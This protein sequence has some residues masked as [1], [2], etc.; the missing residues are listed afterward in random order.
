MSRAKTAADSAAAR[1][2]ALAA[3]RVERAAKGGE[4]L[5]LFAAPASPADPASIP[6]LPSAPGGNG[7]AGAGRPK[8][9]PNKRDSKLRQML[10]ARGFRMPED[11]LAEMAGLSDRQG[12]PLIVQAMAMAEQVLAWAHEGCVDK[13]GMP[14]RPE[15]GERR[16]TLLAILGEMRRA[17]DALLPYG[18]AKMSPDTAVNVQATTIV[19]PGAARPGD[20]ARVVEGR[21]AQVGPSDFAPPPLPGETV[22]NQ[23]L[24]D[25]AEAQSDG[26]SRTE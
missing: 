19:M 8:G 11:V 4:Q 9:S 23:S 26:E 22:E 6:A 3:E 15:P 5:G 25:S 1:T 10:A 7:A 16:A 17:G 2:A 21:A 12:R 13:N 18:L 20:G 14:T 24:D